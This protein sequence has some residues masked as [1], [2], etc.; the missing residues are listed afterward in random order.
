VWHIQISAI[1]TMSE[2]PIGPEPVA[3]W[4]RSL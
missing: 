2:S 4:F 1:T 3:V